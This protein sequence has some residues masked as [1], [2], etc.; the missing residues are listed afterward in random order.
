MAEE[1]ASVGVDLSFAPVL[2][3]NSN[4]A[5]PVIGDR[6][7]DSDP[8]RVSDMGVA[9]MRGLQ[10]GGVIPCGKHFPG[11]G[12]TDTDSHVELPVVRRPRA[13]LERTELVPFRA[14]I[15]AGVPML[16][17]AHV[18]YPAFDAD[19]PAT[20]AR[21]ILTDLLR[22]ELAFGGVV[23]SDDLAMRAI[24]EHQTVGDAAVATLSAG[25]DVLLACQELVHAQHAHAAIDAA[26]RDGRLEEAVIDAACRRVQRLTALRATVRPP[27]CELPNAA[28]RALVEEVLR[29]TH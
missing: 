15:A 26:V 5:N 6:A 16:M 4:P 24:A 21:T 27:A 12:D 19:H 18:L 9:M 7:F 25:A 23:A 17:T 10:D 28:H 20:L 3:V 8:Q 14:A 22:N 13:A 2:D 11:H 29:K 1:L